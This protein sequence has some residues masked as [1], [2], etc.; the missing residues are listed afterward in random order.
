MNCSDFKRAGQSVLMP[1]SYKAWGIYVA[2]LT[3]LPRPL[4]CQPT[5]HE[6]TVNT[7]FLN[8]TSCELLRSLRSAFDHWSLQ[9]W[10][11]CRHKAGQVN[12]FHSPL[13]PCIV[14]PSYPSPDDSIL[15]V[16]S[17]TLGTNPWLWDISIYTNSNSDFSFSLNSLGFCTSVDYR[18]CFQAP[19]PSTQRQHCPKDVSIAV[20]KHHD[21]K[22]SI[23]PHGSREIRV[24]HGMEAQR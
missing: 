5:I 22:Q 11:L 2:W 7:F 16:F 21:Q 12:Y 17:F 9:E 15:L 23:L 4:A 13:E 14:S 20:T 18:P 6:A 1:V 3:R 8:M 24:H 10:L 19:H